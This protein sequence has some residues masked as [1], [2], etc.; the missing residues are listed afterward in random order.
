MTYRFYIRGRTWLGLL[1][2]VL[3]CL[4][5]RVL[6]HHVDAGTKKTLRWSVAKSSDFLEAK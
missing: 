4:F 6:V 5:D 1:N 3:A 2:T